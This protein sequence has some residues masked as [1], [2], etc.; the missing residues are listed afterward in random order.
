MRRVVAFAFL[1]LAL[2]IAAWANGID[3]TNQFGTISINASG[4][5]SKGSELT[6]F[7]GFTAP[8][9]H[10]M[11]TVSYT[12]GALTSGSIAAGG[13]FAGGSASSFVVVGN[14]HYGVPVKGTLFSGEFSGPVTWTLVSQVHQKVYYTLTGNLTGQL[15]TGRT[16]TGSTTQQ[17]YSSVGQLS[18]GIGHITLGST[19]LHATPEPGTLGL[20][21]TGLVGIAGTFRRRKKA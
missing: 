5:T 4:I 17:I 2:P 10:S 7:N 3:L 6:S 1:A 12:T 9:K 13:T 18:S 8:A 15:Y 14:G 21:G 16:V 11:G 20:L 19:N